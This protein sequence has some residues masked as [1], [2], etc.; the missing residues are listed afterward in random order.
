MTA[1]EIANLRAPGPRPAAHSTRPASASP[2]AAPAATNLPRTRPSASGSFVR[3]H[4]VPWIFAAKT[5]LS[6]LLTQLIAF[7]FNLDQPKWALLTV[8]IVAQPASGM[9]LAKSVHRIIGTFIGVA[10]ALLFVA[11]FAQE[12]VLFLGALAAWIGICTFASQYAKS[13]AAYGFVL[14]GYSAAIVGIPGALDP[15]NAFYVATARVTEIS[16]G[17]VVTAAVSHLILPVSVAGMLRQELAD[18]RSWFADY[19]LAVLRRGDDQS[20]RAKLLGEVVRIE[21]LCASAIFEEHEMRGRRDLLR[22]LGAAF[23]EA[24][25]SCQLLMRELVAYRQADAASVAGVS[26]AATQ[27]SLA[28]RSWRSE[29]IT[30][31]RLGERLL[32]AQASLPLVQVLCRDVSVTDGELLRT[33]MIV[34]RLR[35]VFASF[36]AYGEA[37]ERFF[38]SA[39]TGEQRTRFAAVGDWR[40]AAWA[41]LRAVLALLVVAIFWIAAD[42]PSGPT[43]VILS[44]VVTARLATMNRAGEAAIGGTIAVVLGTF[45]AFLII[46]VLLSQ[47][48][49]FEMFALVLAPV[50]FV[51]A[52]L[53]AH[54][55]SPVAVIFGFLFALYLASVGGFADR[56]VY[57]A[58]GFV[59]TSFAVILAIAVGA[60]LFA[61]VAPDTLDAAR[62]RFARVA[63]RAL[64][65][66]TNPASGIPLAEFETTM[67]AALDPLRSHLATKDATAVAAW[68][69]GVALL[70]VG[71]ELIAVAQ[72]SSIAIAQQRLLRELE[73]L[74]SRPDAKRL[75]RVRAL[76]RGAAAE[77]LAGLRSG[78]LGASATRAAIRGTVAFA[79]LDDELGRAGNALLV[80]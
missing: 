31:A 4:W 69:A 33:G 32:R 15:G 41:G 7:T 49:G 58:V 40:G 64:A 54:E 72:D 43:A 19:S 9:V 71:R 22:R 3:P 23:A 60:I 1:L 73:A 34:G 24:F 28:I 74:L 79:T 80:R 59:N 53:M 18:A 20:L 27:A 47:A 37:H 13:F 68:E 25:G 5:T 16:L 26:E 62:R 77:A 57:D 55:K 6:A 61:V 76:C 51:C 56:T 66:A 44:A 35:E 67:V 70:D 46:E 30:A 38:S 2:V 48:S 52:F 63:R 11:L 75:A 45:P 39:P 29:Q 36:A 42:W 21:D 78:T 17:I 50:L 12:R 10:M 65:K 8:F 14:S